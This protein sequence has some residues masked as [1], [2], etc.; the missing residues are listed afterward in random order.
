[1]E[2]G[3][4]YEVDSSRKGI[5]KGELKNVTDE[6]ATFKITQGK[7]QAMML[8]NE[9]YTGEEVTVRREFCKFKEL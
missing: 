1:M 2:I 3:K 5:F 9:R 7:A 6:W 4:E 8:Y